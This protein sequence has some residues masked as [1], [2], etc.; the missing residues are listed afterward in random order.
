MT[1]SD[2]IERLMK[3]NPRGLYV[4][5]RETLEMHQNFGNL[6]RLY[7]EYHTSTVTRVGKPEKGEKKSTQRKRN[8]SSKPKAKVFPP[9]PKTIP[10]LKRDMRRTYL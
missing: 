10:K 2:M 1:S 6:L 7:R 4:Q 9:P 8:I 3:G 5:K